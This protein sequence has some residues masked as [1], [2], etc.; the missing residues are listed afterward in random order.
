MGQCHVIRDSQTQADPVFLLC[1]GSERGHSRQE[2]REWR[3][4]G[5]QGYSS[6]PLE[7]LAEVGLCR[8][9][10]LAGVPGSAMGQVAGTICE[11]FFPGQDMALGAQTPEFPSQH[12]RWVLARL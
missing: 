11:T 9:E 6:R 3:V 7:A 1:A 5:S 10:H 8:E 4:L 2:Q 12:C